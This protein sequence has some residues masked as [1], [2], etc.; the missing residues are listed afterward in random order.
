MQVKLE[1][2]DLEGEIEEYIKSTAKAQYRTHKGQVLFMLN[3]Y[4][5]LKTEKENECNC[6]YCRGVANVHQPSVSQ[7]HQDETM[8][9][10]VEANIANDPQTSSQ[11]V[12]DSGYNEEDEDDYECYNEDELY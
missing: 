5:I 7:N 4:R 3:E 12:D 8:R 6:C 9:Q 11:I 1:P 10:Y 2:K